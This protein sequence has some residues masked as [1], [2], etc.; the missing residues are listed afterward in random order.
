MKKILITITLF[1]IFIYNPVIAQKNL[2]VNLE[3]NEQRIE[4]SCKSKSGTN[5]CK[6][7]KAVEKGNSAI[8]CNTKVVDGNCCK[9]GVDKEKKAQC[10]KMSSIGGCCKN[11]VNEEASQ[12]ISC[13]VNSE[14]NQSNQNKVISDNPWWKIW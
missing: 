8:S 1:C 2:K 13:K 7:N 10:S 11:K 6:K 14:L 5:N 9:N 12:P 3:N 4:S